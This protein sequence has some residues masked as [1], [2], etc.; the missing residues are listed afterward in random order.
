MIDISNI[1]GKP[2]V[3]LWVRSLAV[4]YCTLFEM[5]VN[6]VSGS[7]LSVPP[8]TWCDNASSPELGAKVYTKGAKLRVKDALMRAFGA[9]WKTQMSKGR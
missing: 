3:F 8:S 4:I 1:Y 5:A 2:S 6:V 7:R 9:G